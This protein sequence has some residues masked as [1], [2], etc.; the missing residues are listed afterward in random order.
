MGYAREVRADEP[1]PNH[2]TVAADGQ[3]AG[4]SAICVDG[5]G[6]D[7]ELL[8]GADALSREEVLRRRARRLRNLAECYRRHYWA[9]M[10]EVRVKHRD[11]YWEYG[12]SPLEEGPSEANGRGFG[13]GAGGR[14]LLVEDGAMDRNEE[15][16]RAGIGVGLGFGEGEAG[17][18]GRREERKRCAFA[19]CKSKAMPLTRF[20]HPHILADTNQTLYKACTYVMKNCGQNRPITCGKPILR[21]TVPSLCHVHLQK[22]QRGISQAYR[23]AGHTTSSS[24]PAPKFSVVLAQFV[25]QIKDRRKNDP[26][27]GANGIVHMD[28]KRKVC[29]HR[30]ADT[31]HCYFDLQSL[32]AFFASTMLPPIATSMGVVP[33]IMSKA[34]TEVQ[35]KWNFGI[36]TDAEVISGSSRRRVTKI[37]GVIKEKSD[38]L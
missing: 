4:P 9:L 28:G 33:V 1:N 22:T 12:E 2:D 8:N 27:C 3:E 38:K 7:D 21:A 26:N 5:S 17:G 18:G 6:D 30:D 35:E 31:W 25:R 32:L 16:G 23:K 24:K 15:N 10:E 36:E 20:C 34:T 37:I 29:C 14:E 19:G 11:F 13:A